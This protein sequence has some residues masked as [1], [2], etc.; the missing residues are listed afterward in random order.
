[1]MSIDSGRRPRRLIRHEVRVL[2]LAF[3]LGLPTFASPPTAA[4]D[5][6]TFDLTSASAV[7]ALLD[8]SSA[9]PDAIKSAARLPGTQAL[10]AKMH[11]Y[12][13]RA[14]TET[15]ELAL[16]QMTAV[17]PPEGQQNRSAFDYAVMRPRAP[18]AN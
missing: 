13:P 16:T 8:K 5:G 3:L 4:P 7:L 11:R 2:V 1:M 17:N 14:T 9:T 6:F 15:F 12:D 10:I 18:G